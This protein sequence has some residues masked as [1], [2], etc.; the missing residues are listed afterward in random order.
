MYISFVKV[1]VDIFKNLG[2][3]GEMQKSSQ[4]F[5]VMLAPQPSTQNFFHAGFLFLRSIERERMGCRLDE[6]RCSL[7]CVF[8]KP[9]NKVKLNHIGGHFQGT[10]LKL[11]VFWT[12]VGSP[13]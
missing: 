11:G 13:F 4:N 10:T 6:E 7:F 3:G 8:V 1:D 2:G 12:Y 5:V 9:D